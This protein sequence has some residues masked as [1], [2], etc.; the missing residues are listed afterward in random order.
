MRILP[1]CES[2]SREPEQWRLSIRNYKRSRD[3]Y[4]RHHWGKVHETKAGF[5]RE[6]LMAADESEE[7]RLT[8][9][10]V[11]FVENFGIVH[12]WSSITF[13]DS[14]LPYIMLL[15]KL[16]KMSVSSCCTTRDTHVVCIN[17]GRTNNVSFT[18]E[19][20]AAITE[21]TFQKCGKMSHVTIILK[22]LLIIATS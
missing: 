16:A 13:R 21:T 19:V 12:I 11:I 1:S 3:I 6:L 10:Q 8:R 2:R 7:D 5:A 15:A 20:I 14:K 22:K 17:L 9:Q 18:R 4:K